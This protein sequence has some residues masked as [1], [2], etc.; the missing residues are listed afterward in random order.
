MKFLVFVVM[1]VSANVWAGVECSPYYGDSRVPQSEAL[2]IVSLDSED[3]KT[4]TAL[5]K[6][7]FAP[8]PGVMFVFESETPFTNQPY[9]RGLQ[10][11]PYRDFQGLLQMSSEICLAENDCTTWATILFA[12][13]PRGQAPSVTT[14]MRCLFN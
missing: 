1:F 10:Q 9:F 6:A 14:Y 13:S 8:E 5:V 3:G 2:Q 12:D 4:F 11:G 7:P